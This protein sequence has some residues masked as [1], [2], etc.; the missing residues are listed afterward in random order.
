M[1]ADVIGDAGFPELD[2][3]IVGDEFAAAG[4]LD[5]GLAEWGPRVEGAED[6]P[7]SAVK[8]AGDRTEDLALSSF[9]AAWGAEDQI[10]TIFLHGGRRGRGLKEAAGSTQARMCRLR[11]LPAAARRSGCR[12]A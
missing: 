10:G 11:G 8:E 1:R 4:V 7:A 2:G 5:E 3:E 12:G 9:P 6:I